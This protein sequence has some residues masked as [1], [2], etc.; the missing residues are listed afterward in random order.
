M[1]LWIPITFAAAFLQN[2]RTALQKRASEKASTLAAT[3]TRY[4][5][6]FPFAGTYIAV[7][8][9]LDIRPTITLNGTF[10]SYVATGA[11]AQILATA[12][13]LLLFRF[14]SFA[15]GTAF[16]KTETVQTAVIGAF[17]LGDALTIQAASAIGISLLG[18]WFL[19]L[20]KPGEGLRGFLVGIGW[21]S[22]ACGLLSGALFGLSAVSFRG[23]ALSLGGEGF[24]LQ[25]GI[26]LAAAIGIQTIL[27]AI[28]LRWREKGALT[29][30]ATAWRATGAVSLSGFLG[31]ICWF[32]AMTIQNAAYVRALGQIELLFT[33]A[34]SHFVF[35][36]KTTPRECLG[37]ALVI[38][39]LLVLILE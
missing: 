37:V 12:A 24:L 18:V 39:G 36:E 29:K 38:G 25:A 7:L 23:A 33:F 6:A 31:S 22:A 30:L 26:T 16:S 9:L 2:L 20:S 17:L 19:V 5:F 34:T 13:L 35:R 21:R 4:L 3:M 28:W 27:L 1:D 11:V 8:W 15:V 10:W 32:T 14:R